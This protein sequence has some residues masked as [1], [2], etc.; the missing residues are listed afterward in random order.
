MRHLTPGH[1]FEEDEPVKAPAPEPEKQV[2][3]LSTW[4]Q[5]VERAWAGV[6]V[7][8]FAFG[9]VLCLQI[10]G[11]GVP[12]TLMATALV[13]LGPGSGLVQL[14]G[15]FDTAVKFVVAIGTS[16]AISVLV[17]QILL[18]IGS[19]GVLQAAVPLTAIT[20]AGLAL[21]GRSLWKSS[22]RTPKLP[23]SSLNK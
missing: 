4:E 8:T 19:I 14:V 15:H 17:A 16:V 7:A 1:Q 12:R 22:R 3:E 23:R 2:R 6:N 18:A 11:P 20:G 5:G 9:L 13:L 21:R 10:M